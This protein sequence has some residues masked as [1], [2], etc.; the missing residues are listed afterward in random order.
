MKYLLSI[1]FSICLFSKASAAVIPQ[2]LI[3]HADSCSKAVQISHQRL[4]KYLASGAQTDEDKVLIFSYWIAKNI[5]YNLKEAREHHRTNKTAYEVLRNQNAV[6]EGY[7]ILFQQFCLDQEI[8][9]YVVYGHGYGNFIK[10]AFS[11][12]HMRHAWNVVYLNGQW[13]LL[14]VTWASGEMKHTDFEKTRELSWIFAD[15]SEFIKTHYPNDPRWQLLKSPASRREF[16][17]QSPTISEKQYAL[18]DSLSVLL[19][20]ER[21][22]NEVYI[23][24]SEFE[25]QGDEYVYIKNLIHLGWSYVGG[26]F[27]SE[28]VK[29]GIEIF[30]FAEAE[31]KR[32]H[33]PLTQVLYQPDIKKG[34]HTAAIRL[35]TKK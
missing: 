13:K 18:E 35:E 3:A 20:R 10:R 5:S 19:H 32:I 25:E 17:S 22:L 34:I 31:L 11:M 1:V 30:S 8:P 33:T 23:C 26:S 14:D 12:A 24:K 16:W 29:Q 4:S 28:K 9:C 27:D 15:P 7:A 2:S 6:C 21:Y